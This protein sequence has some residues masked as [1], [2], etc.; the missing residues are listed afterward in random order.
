MGVD[1]DVAL[2]QVESPVGHGPDVGDEPECGDHGVCREHPDGAVRLAGDFDLG[3]GLV[4]A[5]GS[6]FAGGDEFD[7]QVP[8]SVDH[9]RVGTELIAT[10]HDRHALGQGVQ[11]VSP[12][13][14]GIP[15]SYD[16]D[17]LAGVRLRLGDE[18]HEAATLPFTTGW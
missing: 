15:A 6:H 9:G 17:I 10:V 13:E 18:E 14:G 11:H 12:V 1:L 2:L 4:A 8:S 7:P 3:D 16:H 5:N